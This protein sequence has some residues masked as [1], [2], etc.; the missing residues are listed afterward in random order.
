M[1][2]SEFVLECVVNISEGSDRRLLNVFD[3]ACGDALLDRHSDR[4]HNRSVYTLIGTDAQ[5]GS[6]VAP[7]GKQLGRSGVVVGLK[8]NF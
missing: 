7:N 1:C 4:D 5:K 8:Y 3:E 2:Q 6:Y